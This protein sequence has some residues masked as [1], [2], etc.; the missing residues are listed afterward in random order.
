MP[1]MVVA[2]AGTTELA[3]IDPLTPICKITKEYGLWFHV[4]GAVGGFYAMCD[5]MKERLEGAFVL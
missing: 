2:T 3:S 1:F 4:D 5:S